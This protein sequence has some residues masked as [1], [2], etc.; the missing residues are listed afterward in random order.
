MKKLNKSVIA[1]LIVMTILSFTN[2]LNIKIYI[3]RFH[4]LWSCI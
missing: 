1:L 4:I 2:F 3:Y